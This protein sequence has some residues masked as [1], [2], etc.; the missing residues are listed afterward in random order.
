MKR[1]TFYATVDV[2]VDYDIE[3]EDLLEII[4]SCD[5]EELNEIRYLIGEQSDNSGFDAHNL[6]DESK[7][8]ILKVDFKKYEL[9]ELMKRLDINNNEY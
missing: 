2:D 4:E 9:D 7:L 6:Y 1:K 5:E 3:F 8:K